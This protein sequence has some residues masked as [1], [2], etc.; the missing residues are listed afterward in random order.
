MGAEV[1]ILANPYTYNFL[2]GLTHSA[3]VEHSECFKG[4][5]LL[6]WFP[7]HGH[8]TTIIC[9]G[10]KRDCGNF[11]SVS[12]LLRADDNCLHI[13]IFLNRRNPEKSQ[14]DDK[15]N[16][17]KNQMGNKNN[18]WTAIIAFAFSHQGFDSIHFTVKTK[19]NWQES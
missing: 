2:K 6:N 1:V 4:K 18:S 5:V 9:Q 8:S 10:S 13:K 3:M 16:N 17:M 15:E 19:P 14:E 11:Y 12:L 7:A